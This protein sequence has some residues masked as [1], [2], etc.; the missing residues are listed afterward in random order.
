[1]IIKYMH[2]Q[3]LIRSNNDY[4]RSNKF[5]LTNYN[6]RRIFKMNKITLTNIAGYK[7]KKKK[8]RNFLLN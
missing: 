7:W 8:R 6:Y 1:M 2:K 3:S 5:I 4:S